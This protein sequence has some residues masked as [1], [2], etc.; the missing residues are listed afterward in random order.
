MKV[1]A[2][3]L[4]TDRHVAVCGM[5]RT[6]KSLLCEEYLARYPYVV[7]L[8]TKNECL[9]R[10]RKAENVWSSLVEGEDF[11]VVFSLE[12]AKRSTLDRIVYVPDFEEQTE[13]GFNQFFRWIFE[14]EN[15]IVWVD[16]LM[17]VAT[18]SKIPKELHRLVILGNSKNVALW[19]CTQ[20]PTGIPN[21]V[22]ANSTYFFTF[23]LNL[24][25]DRK[26]LMEITGC[27]ELLEKP[28]GHYFWFY[29]M[30]EEKP[31]KAILRR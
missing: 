23:N 19:A 26:K 15:T 13:E 7:K 17:T 3:H 10:R 5:T 1:Q 11:E 28:T 22:L 30:G 2:F 31:V 27:E 8:D 9:E 4:P 6:G 24:P 14:R 18:S 16:E 12:D 25:Q 21:I 20:R 29:S